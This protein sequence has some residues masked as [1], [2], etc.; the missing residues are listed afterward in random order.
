MAVDEAL[1]ASA[2][3]AEQ[4]SLRLYTWRGPW[5]SLGYAQILSSERRSRCSA[6][7][8]RVVRRPSGGRAVLHGRDL[9]YAVAAPA[10][11]FPP[12]LEASYRLVS[13]A[14]LAAL[15]RLGISAHRAQAGRARGPQF[16]C[17]AE[18]AREEVVVEDRK[19]VGSAQRR[20]GEALL[21]H[22]SIRLSPDPP[23]AVAAAGLGQA[24]TSLS[25]LG[26]AAA[27]P[28]LREA[29]IGA[30]A[31]H[32]EADLQPSELGVRER[33]TARRRARRLSAE[34]PILVRLRVPAAS[35]APLVG[36]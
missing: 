17:F 24:A 5:L 2:A 29:L 8:V 9:T 13:G 15:A 32:L 12:E 7:G 26:A 33:L 23:P 20:T 22:G 1:L 3:E 19:L 16:D 21:Q 28:R 31:A 14:I 25:E 4:A 35:R 30:F 27:L 36:R 34:S 18:P 10:S 11:W 6:A